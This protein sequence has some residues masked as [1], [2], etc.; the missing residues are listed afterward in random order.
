M[1]SDKVTPVIS[2]VTR[3]RENLRFTW[4]FALGKDAVVNVRNDII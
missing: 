3:Y 1:N 4:N 2:D